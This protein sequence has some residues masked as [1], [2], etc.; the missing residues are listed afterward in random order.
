MG[1]ARDELT[2][3]I[4]IIN[5]N[6]KAIEVMDGWPRVV[7]FELEGE[8]GMFFLVVEKGQAKLFDKLTQREVRH[9]CAWQRQGIC[10]RCQE[11]AGY[12]SPSC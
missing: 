12:K 11:R 10:S 3:V 6:P 2:K 9:Y 1:E 5:S 7:Q 8:G 4:P